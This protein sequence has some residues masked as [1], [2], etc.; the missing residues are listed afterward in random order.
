MSIQCRSLSLLEVLRAKRASLLHELAENNE[1]LK[2]EHKNEEDRFHALVQHNTS[3]ITT[4]TSNLQHVIENLQRSCRVEA[5]SDV[6]VYLQ[7]EPDGFCGQTTQVSQLSQ[8]R[9]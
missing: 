5:R 8:A 1:E 4:I 7:E 6:R 3:T 9:R 2:K